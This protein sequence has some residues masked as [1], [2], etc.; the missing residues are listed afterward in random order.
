M[1]PLPINARRCLACIEGRWRERPEGQERIAISFDEFTEAGVHRS[2][3]RSSLD[4]LL[5]LGLVE[6]ADP[7]KGP[8]GHPRGA[9]RLR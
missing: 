7:V 2:L 1:T 8:R 6:Q 5:A 9:Y 3:V 4:I